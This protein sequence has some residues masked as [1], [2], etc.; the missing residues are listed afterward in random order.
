MSGFSFTARMVRIVDGDTAVV[1]P[2]IYPPDTN[3]RV[4]FKDV[5]A[6]ETDEE[7]GAEATEAAMKM[8]PVG[9]FLV[10]TNTRSHFSFGRLEARVDLA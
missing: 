9:S 5:F 10:L 3:M 1:D 6:P 4:R 7:G 2:S 8:F